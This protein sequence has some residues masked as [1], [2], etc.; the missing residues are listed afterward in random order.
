MAGS[1]RHLPGGH[2]PER[3]RVGAGRT[4]RPGALLPRPP[5]RCPCSRRGA[6][7]QGAAGTFIL[8]LFLCSDTQKHRVPIG[9]GMTECA[10]VLA[11]LSTVY[12]LVGPGSV[13]FLVQ[14][15][16]SIPLDPRSWILRTRFNVY[17]RFSF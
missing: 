5:A 12:G 3:R 2:L 17:V 14:D 16:V 8:P 9:S 1:S 13:A 11:Y 10:A 15:A 4:G 7:L 6:P